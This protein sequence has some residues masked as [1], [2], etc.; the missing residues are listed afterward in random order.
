MNAL[1]DMIVPVAWAATGGE[2]HSPSIAGLIFPL[3]NFLIFAYLAKRYAIPPIKEYL[4]KRREN[5]INSVAEANEA[6]SEAEKYLETYKN[7]LK[8][9][10]AESEKIRTE[11]REEAEREKARVVAE[12]EEFAAKLKADADFLAEQ[13]MKMARQQ[14]R[15]ELANLA[16]EAAERVIAGNLTD[17]DQERLISDF[18]Q[19]L[20]RN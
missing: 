19:Q 3:I 15:A 9:L 7:K 18:A 1:L 20:S 17:D 10:A 2:G 11:L 12:A 13:E 6:R 16:E 14:I 5:V 4:R 8:D